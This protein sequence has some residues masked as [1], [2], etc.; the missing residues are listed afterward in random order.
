MV[1]VVG[2][3]FSLFDEFLVA[4]QEHGVKTIRVH[5][6]VAMETLVIPFLEDEIVGGG[7]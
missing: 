4:F 6:C 5:I 3:W 2:F 7:G 1:T